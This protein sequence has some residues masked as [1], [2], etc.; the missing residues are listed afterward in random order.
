VVVV[1]AHVMIVV[2]WVVVVVVVSDCFEWLISLGVWVAAGW[3]VV[4]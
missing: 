1:E 2:V 3:L 4:E